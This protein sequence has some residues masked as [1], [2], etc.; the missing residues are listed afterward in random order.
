MKQLIPPTSRMRT[1]TEDQNDVACCEE[2]DGSDDDDD[3]RVSVPPKLREASSS[4][5]N[6]EDYGPY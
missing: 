4:D 5:I 6:S 1:R 3:C 2:Q